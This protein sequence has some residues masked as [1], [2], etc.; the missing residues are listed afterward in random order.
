MN[1]SELLKL[2]IYKDNSVGL[3]VLLSIEHLWDIDS[4]E[5]LLTYIRDRSDKISERLIEVALT[6]S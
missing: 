1:P 6:S 3:E 2:C 5:R 4:L